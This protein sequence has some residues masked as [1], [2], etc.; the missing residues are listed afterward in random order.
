M[1]GRLANRLRI[2]GKGSAAI[3]YAIIFPALLV[4]VL[5]VMDTGRLLWTYST[6]HRAT[7]AAA[8]CGAVNTT[9]CGNA[10]Q[11]RNQ[12]VAAAWGLTVTSQM[13][14]VSSPA[15][16]LQV[17]ATFSFVFTI[18]GFTSLTLRATSCHPS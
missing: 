3:E 10:A 1:M 9:T 7:A 17:S 15:C 8:R 13:F 14:T 4:F 2:G 16:G 18:P 6:L 5:G 11:I 12:A